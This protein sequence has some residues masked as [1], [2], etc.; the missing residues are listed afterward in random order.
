MPCSCVLSLVFVYSQVTRVEEDEE[1]DGD[2]DGDID[3][4]EESD[5]GEFSSRLQ[6]RKRMR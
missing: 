6:K 3:D 5:K 1:E 2:E 4:N